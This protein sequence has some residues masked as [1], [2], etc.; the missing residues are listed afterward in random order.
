MN[1]SEWL[2]TKDERYSIITE[3]DLVCDRS[4]LADM[5]TTFYFVG[6]MLSGV[7]SGKFADTFG[8]RLTML[9]LLGLTVVGTLG[10]GFAGELWQLCVLKVVQ[11]SGSP[12]YSITLIYLMELMPAKHQAVSGLLYQ[13]PFCFSLLVFDGVGYLV[14]RWRTLHFYVALPLCVFVFPFVF[15]VE[16]PRWLLSVGNVEG[17]ER[18]LMRVARFNKSSV[19]CKLQ[20]SFC[21]EDSNKIQHEKTYTYL[22]LFRNG[23]V[24][25]VIGSLSSLWFTSS[26]VYYMMGLESS[27]LGGNM[28]QVF[29]FSTMVEIPG[30]FIAMYLCNRYGRK[31]IILVCSFTSGLLT[32]AIATVPTRLFRRELV[33]ICL[34]LSTKLLVNIAYSAMYVWSFELVPTVVRSQGMLFFSVL[35]NASGLVVPFLVGALQNAMYVLPFVIAGVVT[36]LGALF[37]TKLPETN[38]RPTREVYDDFFH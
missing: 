23:T 4:S 32:A 26:M 25:F 21:N 38:N 20:P 37:G 12:L 28:Y 29:A 15:L 30:P 14:R 17:A 1:R 19:N 11:G 36:S 10:C 24:A 6:A 8:R 13:T 31:K 33:N 27:R 5:T 22:D 9:L 7:V 3:F 16:S 35:V 34:S 18:S 2:F